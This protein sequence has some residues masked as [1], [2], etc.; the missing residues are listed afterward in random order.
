MKCEITLSA[1]VGVGGW[2]YD[3]ATLSSMFLS[4]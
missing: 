3:F 1:A 2:N 4:Y